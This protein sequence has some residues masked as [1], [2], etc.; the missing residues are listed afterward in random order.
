MRLRFGIRD[1]LWLTLVEAL[2]TAWRLDHRQL[3]SSLDKYSL[4]K[5]KEVG[6]KFVVVP[7]AGLEVEP[8]SA[9][10]PGP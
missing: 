2:Y 1:L 6:G 5:V 7:F 8:P 10:S 4:P 3:R 9:A